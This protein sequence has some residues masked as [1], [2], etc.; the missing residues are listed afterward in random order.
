MK[1]YDALIGVNV[2]L[3]VEYV[4]ANICF[5]IS[6]LLGM[7]KV[8]YLLFFCIVYMHMVATENLERAIKKEEQE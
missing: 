8:F 5:L 2:L 7:E 4:L 6:P 1:V 3:W